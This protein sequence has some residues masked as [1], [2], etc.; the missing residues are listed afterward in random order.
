ML[1]E[2]IDLM[3]MSADTIWI[4]ICTVLVFFMQTGFAMLE[5]GF[6]RKKNSCNV[7]M[8][9]IMDFAVGSIFYWILGFGIMFGATTGVVG[10]IDLFSNGDCSA[11]SQTIPQPVFMA[12]QLVFCAT[13]ATIVS[14]AMAERTAFKSYLIY[15]AVMSAVVYP[16]S[17]CW[18]WNANGWLAQLGFHDFAGG[19]AV[20]LLGGS[21]A[22]AGAAVLGARIGKYDKKKKSRAILGQNIP[23][24]ALGAFILWVSWFGFNGGSV[25]TSES[26]FDLVAI[27]SVFMNTILS[28]SACAVSAMIITWVRYGKSDITMTLNGIVA[29]LVAVTAG[30]DQLPHYAALLVGVGAAFVMIYGIEFI[31]HI[32]KVDDPVGAISVHGLCGAFGTIMTGVFSVE[33]GVIYTGRFNFLGVQ[34]IGVLSVAV[35]GL[36]AMTLLFV[37]LKHTV[38]IRVSEKAEI[39]GLDRSEHGWQSNVTDDLISDLSDGNAKSVTQIDLSKPIDRSAYKADGKIR[40]VVI[41]MNSSKFE[42]LKDA[43]DEIDITGMTVTNVNGCG[44]QKGSTDYYCG[45]EAK[46]HLLPKIKVEIVI[47]TVPLGLLVDTVKRVLYSGNIGDGKIFVYEVENVIKIRTDEE[48]KMALE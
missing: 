17:G 8:K 19:T 33:K 45:S 30:A 32:C 26:G 11:A 22:F 48:G 3:I 37:I 21:A 43:L 9:N 34:L 12:W 31:D 15:S 2:R 14:G 4:A 6:T 7:I 13:S 35:Y 1:S 29:G 5:T 38:G 24:A 27:G 23:L 16:I 41:L 46:S 40:K 36:A 10:V 20:H 39:M 47:S 44:I 42:S 25:V 28:S 18:I